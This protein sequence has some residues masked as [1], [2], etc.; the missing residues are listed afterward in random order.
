M[1]EEQ[2]QGMKVDLEMKALVII[3]IFCLMKALKFLADST[4]FVYFCR[5]F[6]LLGHA[7]FVNIYLD[8]NFR[9]SKSTS[10][11]AEEKQAAKSACFSVFKGIMIR[12]VLM[13]FI[14]LRTNILPPLFVTVFMGFFSLI[15][16]DFFYQLLYSK[17]P[18]LFELLYR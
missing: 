14:H 8:T 12:A 16:N 18:S 17:F 1:G 11:T 9:L 7:F 5:L 13:G 2:Y 3:S 15:E 4:E 10:R 6:F